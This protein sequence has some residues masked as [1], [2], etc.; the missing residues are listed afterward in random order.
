MERYLEARYCGLLPRLDERSRRLV[1]AADGATSHISI[2]RRGKPLIR[3]EVILQLI[4]AASTQSGLC[5]T[6][7]SDPGKYPDKLKVTDQEMESLN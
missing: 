3:H 2:Y 7:Q 1:V 4:A 5:V 6:A